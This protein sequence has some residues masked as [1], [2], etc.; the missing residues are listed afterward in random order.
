MK[1]QQLLFLRKRERKEGKNS[2]ILSDLNSSCLRV[3]PTVAWDV[4][5]LR[6]SDREE[7]TVLFS[8][9]F[10]S[11][12]LNFPGFPFPGNPGLFVIPVSR[13]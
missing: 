13:G 5:S 10:G 3:L 12:R 1:A 6:F 9:S 7:E 11:K 2:C 4:H 8:H